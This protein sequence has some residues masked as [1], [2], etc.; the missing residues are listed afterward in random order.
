VRGLQTVFLCHS[1]RDEILVKA[2]IALLQESGWQLYV[3]WVDGS[4]PET[5]TRETAARIQPNV[6]LSYFIFLATAN[7][8]SSRWCPWETGYADGKKSLDRI[9][10]LPTTDGGRTHGNEYLEL[11]RRIDL[12]TM[13]KLGV[14]QPG[15]TSHGVFIQNL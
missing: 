15:E 5:P 9:V 10:V 7:S 1:H 6:E 14:W 4:M 2:L 11:Y 13:Q 12:S 8:M 3:D